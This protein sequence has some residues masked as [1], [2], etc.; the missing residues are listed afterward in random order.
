MMTIKGMVLLTSVAL[1]VGFAST[2]SSVQGRKANAKT[3]TLERGKAVYLANCARC[4]GGD[5]LGQTTMGRMVE[6]PD[7]SDAKWQAKRSASRMVA[8]VTRGRGQMPAFGKKLSKS[9]IAAA[10]LYVRTLKK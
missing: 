5:G 1:F 4:H 10:I 8:S 7:I 3:Q 6:S 2:A 9:E